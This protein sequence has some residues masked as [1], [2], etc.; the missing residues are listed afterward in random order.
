MYKILAKVLANRL[1]EF[2]PNL[3]SE[4]QSTFV[5]SRNISDNVLVALELLHFMKR[6]NRGSEGEVALKL[7]I[8]KAYDWVDWNFLRN[9][10]KA[11]GFSDKWIKWI[12]LCVTTVS[13]MINFNG[14]TVGPIVPSR[15]L[16]QGDSLSPYLFLFCVEGLSE[17]ISRAAEEGHISGCQIASN[18]PRVTHL[19]FVDDSFLFFKSTEAEALSI[20]SL[21]NRYEA[22]SGQAVNYFKSGIFFSAN[23]RLDK[24]QEV[25]NILEVNND[26]KDSKYLGLPSFV[27]RSKKAVFSFIKE[28][29]WRRVQDWSHKNL[30]KAGKTVMVKNVGQTIPSYSMSCFLLPK[31]MCSE[32]E[33]LLNGYWWGSRSNNSKGIR[34]LGWGRMARPKS[35][36]GLGFRDLYGFNLALLGKQVWKFCNNPQSLVTRLFKSRYFPLDNILNATKGSSSSFVW[37][38]I[39][40]AKEHLR[41]GF[42]WIVGDGENIKIFKDPW[43]KGKRDFCVEDSHVNAVRNEKVCCYFCP[44]SKDWDVQKVQQDFHEDDIRLIL[45]TRIPQIMARDKVAWTASSTGGYTVKTG[46]QYWST[47]NTNVANNMDSDNSSC[48][49]RIWKLRLPHKM[50]TFIWRFCNNNIHVRNLLRSKGVATTI[51]CLM[52]NT[53]VEHMLHIFFFD[54]K[55]AS[56]CWEKNGS[57]V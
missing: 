24:Q 9:R 11:M 48:W 21:L 49:N 35:A 20:K 18:A 40:E 36:G 17:S 54:C 57:V 32:L 10:M 19:L 15:G 2:L 50:R 8:S 34:L 43:L 52:C 55:F 38:G 12:M 45:Q 30:S 23:V 33:R 1:K 51:I 25:R 22:N 56:D 31:S 4:N 16:R 46:Y 27:G 26:L 39:W 7:D 13:Y 42:R 29:V 6:K 41:K 28:R 5:P 14:I 47:Q 53:D 3:I 37:A 44:N